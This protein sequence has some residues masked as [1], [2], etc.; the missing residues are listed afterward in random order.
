[1][2]E[3]EEKCSVSGKINC[4]FKS[5]VTAGVSN[6]RKEQ[7]YKVLASNV[8]D[9]EFMQQFMKDKLRATEKFDGTCCLIDNYNGR[10][11][12][13]ARHDVK[14]NKPADKRYKAY[15]HKKNE[16]FLNATNK[17]EKYED[18]VWDLTRDFKEKPDDWK[19]ASGVSLD[20]LASV[21]IGHLVGW[22]PVDPSL[23]TH[24][25][26]LSSVDLNRGEALVLTDQKVEGDS[27]KLQLIK[28]ADY[29]GKT[30]ELIGTHVN[31]NPY[32]IGCKQTPVH[33]LIQHGEFT[34]NQELIVNNDEMNRETL[35]KFFESDPR[36]RIEGI[37]WH[38]CNGNMYKLHRCHL[39][40]PWPVKQ[41]RTSLK[42][43]SVDMVDY[44]DESCYKNKL[45]S[46]LKHVHGQT[47]D[48][49]TDILI[50]SITTEQ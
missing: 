17:E 30:F 32:G 46:L 28:L 13:W 26:H 31:A 27:L 19:S 33:C 34:M 21:Q 1:M 3:L 41:L 40:L 48:K 45:F 11:W 49:L 29:V 8:L 15:Q 43:V 4:I 38:G 12:L 18:F 14:P 2:C 44:N 7:L 5:Q 10:P 22:V 50:P 39:D 23:R 16:F 42:S 37:V 6:K 20:D 25:W 36:G 35:V 9:E 47:Y 24:I